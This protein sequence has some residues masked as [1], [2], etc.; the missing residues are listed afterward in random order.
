MSTVGRSRARILGAMFQG[1]GN[2]SLILPVLA[3]LAARGHAVRVVV[4][5]GIRRSRL[6]VNADLLSRL[7]DAGAEVL[8]LHG[9]A[10]HPLDAEPRIRGVVLGW[11]PGPFRG[12]PAEALT[13]LWAPAWAE[14]VTAELRRAPAD[15]VVADFMLQGALAAA[16]AARIPSIALAHTVLLR[17]I[18]GIPPYGPGWAPAVGPLGRFR[19][20]LGRG[21]VERI[22]RRDGLPALNRARA[23]L[24]LAPMRLAFEQLDGA[25]RVLVLAASA[26]DFPARRDAPANLCY[27]GSPLDD[28]TVLPWMP[29]WPPGDSRQ[30]VVVVA[31]ARRQA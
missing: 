24:G 17:P 31:R 19:D 11:T 14:G 16:E 13:S 22:H 9:P 6:P 23:A 21:I 10:T 3:E 12:A 25:A 30:L 27:V 4:G 26:F 29:P 18:P 15:L 20:A 7:A 5:P 8:S 1:G 2:V 28:V